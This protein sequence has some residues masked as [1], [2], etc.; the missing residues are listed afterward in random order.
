M[1]KLL[2]IILCFS[3]S[4]CFAR[5]ID[6]FKLAEYGTPEQLKAALKE[7]AKFNVKR[8]IYDFDNDIETDDDYWPFD[9]DETPLH[10]AATYN[11]NP[12]SIQFLIHQGLDVNATAYVGN[13]ASLTPLAC[14]VSC[15]N[16]IAVQELLKAGANP[17]AWTVGGYYFV[18]TPFHIVAFEYDDPSVARYVISALI[19][20]GG[21]I[22]SNEQL[23]PEEI[24]ELIKSEP[25]FS[26]NKT[27]FQPR[28]Q[29][30][31][32]NP[33]GNMWDFSHIAT[34]NFLMTL[35]PL[36]WAVLCDKPDIVDVLLD[37]NADVNIRSVE[38]KTAF[39]YANE[40]QISSRIKQS[41]VFKR[42]QS[43]IR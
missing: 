26:V 35:T 24:K 41:L 19:Q 21:D 43:A 29:W 13:S 15:K 10:R 20:A 33:C 16:I 27:I 34:G 4:I 31:D 18:G 17:N 28:S 9:T 25:E 37:F 22:N 6:V 7:G 40:L 42:L 23:S 14:A 38:D 12:D 2:I 3:A 39:D 11:H 32:N 36:M 8:N 5:E 1:K 30:E